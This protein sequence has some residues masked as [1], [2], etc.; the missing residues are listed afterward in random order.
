[1]NEFQK[2]CP[3]ITSED[4]QEDLKPLKE[5]HN[6][7]TQFM[8]E[9]DG[10]FINLSIDPNL[11]PKTGSIF[12]SLEKIQ[13][14]SSI[15]SPLQYYR[16]ILNLKVQDQQDLHLKSQEISSQNLAE[17]S[18]KLLD[19]QELIKNRQS[20]IKK[21]LLS[22]K[23]QLNTEEEIEKLKLRLQILKKD[24][25]LSQ[26]SLLQDEI[27][28]NKETNTNNQEYSNEKKALIEMIEKVEKEKLKFKTKS[29]EII[30]E[31]T[32]FKEELSKKI[33]NFKIESSRLEAENEEIS[34]EIKKKDSIEERENENE[35]VVDRIWESKD[36]I[37]FF[38][39]IQD[40]KL[41]IADFKELQRNC[42]SE[43]CG[44]L[45]PFYQINL[46]Y[47]MKKNENVEMELEKSNS[48][49]MSLFNQKEEKVLKTTEKV[50]DIIK[51]VTVL[52][53]QV[54]GDYIIKIKSESH[55]LLNSYKNLLNE[56]KNTEL[57]MKNLDF[58]DKLLD[59]F[60]KE[61]EL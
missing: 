10:N 1:M 47:D 8:K 58:K 25:I 29:S 38:Q 46:A 43:R 52:A 7:R 19:L 59:T 3:F 39:E 14:S 13:N 36:Y 2:T 55:E 45:E 42:I 6:Q 37:N 54:S 50:S 23:T 18:Q 40:I 53:S 4:I 60:R 51:R 5:Y 56:C 24:S 57:M 34:Q 48:E 16:Q 9:S 32:R 28:E 27:K 61:N 15:L 41:Q 31:K 35:G 11:L 30:K 17:T 21:L 49:W 33:K 26:I 20:L 44:L 12:E 22:Q